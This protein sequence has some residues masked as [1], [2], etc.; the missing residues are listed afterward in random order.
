MHMSYRC[1]VHGSAVGYRPLDGLHILLHGEVGLFE[2]RD[3][4]PRLV[5]C[6]TE[7]SSFPIIGA[8][9]YVAS[10]RAV[11]LQ[12]A[13]THARCSQVMMVPLRE[14]RRHAELGQALRYL[15]E[16]ELQVPQG[17]AARLA[18]AQAAQAR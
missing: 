14:L 6:S 18:V 2:S 5:R 3:G 10:S 17:L 15:L 9:A 8:D 12:T 16:R 11:A 4:P 7:R 1:I 13:A